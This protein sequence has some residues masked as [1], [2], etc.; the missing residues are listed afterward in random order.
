MYVPLFIFN[1]NLLLSENGWTTFNITMLET[2]FI[3]R[4][5]SQ[6][7]WNQKIHYSQNSSIRKGVC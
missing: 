1:H 7:L 3:Q 5:H 6:P 2:A 4:L